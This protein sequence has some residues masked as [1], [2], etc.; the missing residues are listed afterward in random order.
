M[1]GHWGNIACLIEGCDSSTERTVS[2]GR[3]GRSI[4]GAAGPLAIMD[5]QGHLRSR[6]DVG[7]KRDRLL[8][9]KSGFT[10]PDGQDFLVT[11]GGENPN[12][13]R[14]KRIPAGTP[15]LWHAPGKGPQS[16]ANG[17]FAKCFR[18]PS[19]SDS[20]AIFIGPTAPA[21]RWDTPNGP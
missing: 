21:W 3:G 6:E 18:P 20:R 12:I 5:S 4:S 15:L 13:G 17:S 7:K 19:H 9:S 14:G 11:R 10:P 2:L 1:V 16:E 8:P